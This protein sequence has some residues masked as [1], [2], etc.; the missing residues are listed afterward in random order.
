MALEVVWRRTAQT[1]LY[2]L[3]DWIADQADPD[4][5]YAYTSAIE[6]HAAGLTT[7]PQRGTPRDDLAPGVRTS[8]F[9]GRTVI[10]Y[11]V[12]DTVEILRVFHAGKELGLAE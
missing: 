5:A 3:Y 2:A 12:S 1:D 6:A 10:A 9:R 7:Y 8:N 4:T 11:R